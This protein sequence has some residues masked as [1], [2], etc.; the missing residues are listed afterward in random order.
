M[1]SLIPSG[2]APL[3]ERLGGLAARGTYLVVGA[4]GPEKLV[5]VLHFLHEG[6]RSGESVLLITSAEAEEILEVA[7]AW[8]FDLWHA[9]ETGLLQIVGFRDDFEL[10]A[11]RSIAPE[12]VLEELD[13]LLLPDLSRI[14][15][16]PGSMFL[17]GGAHALLGSAFIGWAEAQSATVLATFSIDGG[18]SRMPSSAEWLVH[19]TTGRLLL[20]KRQEGLYQIRLSTALPGEGKREESVTLELVPGR[21][22]V[23]PERYPAR[24]GADRS[25]IDAD[26]LLLVSLGGE[27]STDLETW[28]TASFKTEVVRE[29]FDAVTAVQGGTP[30]GAVLVYAP[31]RRVKD[32]L[33]TCRAIRPLSRAAIVFASDDDVRATDR[34]QLLEVG[35]DDCLSGGLD[36]REVGV[37]IRQAIETGARPAGRDEEEPAP[38]VMG[39]KEGGRVS[40]E[41]FVA[42]VASRGADPLQTFFC[43]LDVTS[44]RL[45]SG[46]LEELLADQIRSEEGDLV[47]ASDRGCAVLLQGARRAQLGP[48]LTRLTALLNEAAGGDAEARLEVLS[49]PSE[50]AEIADFLR[51]PHEAG[52]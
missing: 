28:A 46:R 49:H 47:S 52:V 29:P 25:G 34:I 35:A 23:Q 39:G 2:I 13:D 21:G 3:D 1:P 10:R 6:V 15:V 16:D 8:G 11:A 43:V 45:R 26:S 19:A 40:R 30:Y 36:F 4:P 12:E 14:A 20:E 17:S 42:A 5:A 50:A 33:R 38:T 31:R 9:W 51:T 7:E 27:A 22:L 24:R 32:A 44:E 48:F 18:A 37:R 41:T